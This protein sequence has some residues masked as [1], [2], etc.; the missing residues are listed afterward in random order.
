MI[1]KKYGIWIFM[2]V[3]VLLP[4]GVFAI[5]KWYEHSYTR[6]PEL[7]PRDHKIANFQLTDQTGRTV[8]LQN[9]NDRIVV[10]NLF[11]T[12]CPSVCPKMIRSLKRVQ[13]VYA[14]D[15]QLLINS[16]SVDPERDTVAQL[17]RYASMVDIRNNWQ[18]ITGNKKDIYKLAR[19]SFL[20]VATDG[21]GGPDDFIH[22]ELVVLIDKEK[23]IRGFYN[24]TDEG[25][26]TNLLRDIKRLKQGYVR[27]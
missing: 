17:A 23:H 11:F 6:L 26:V 1:L 25:E 27:K 14:N 2:A 13:Q 20:I 19:K 15:P 12:H 5:V 10:A 3:V 16:F 18:L 4:M 8:S 7:G 24:G 22:S 21:D 9:W